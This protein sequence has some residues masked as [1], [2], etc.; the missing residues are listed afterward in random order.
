MELVINMKN[1]FKSM[2]IILSLVLVICFAGRWPTF[3]DVISTPRQNASE[4]QIAVDP[5][6]NLVAVWI[7]SGLLKSNAAIVGGKLE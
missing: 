1:L 4:P 6:G 5:N 7:E 2:F 3:P